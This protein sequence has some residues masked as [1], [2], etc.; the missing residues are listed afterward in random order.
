M[1][2]QQLPLRLSYAL[3]IHKSQGQTLDKV[4]IDLGN[5]EMA[6][7]CSFV[8]LSRLRKLS[9]CLINPMPFERLT[10]IGKLEGLQKRIA[11]ECL[12]QL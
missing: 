5:K 7:G 3:T 11:E 6:A 2:H 12:Q 8:A 10:K 9:D 4:V 1:S